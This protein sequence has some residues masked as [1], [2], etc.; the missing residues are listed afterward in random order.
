MSALLAKVN[1]ER[2]VIPYNKP[3]LT[4]RETQYLV[5]A[6]NSGKISGNGRFTGKCQ[7]FFEERYGFHKTLLTSSCTDALEMTALLANI[8]PGDEVI[9]PSFTFVSTANAFALRGAKLV[10]CD[11]E[12]A[13]PNIAANRIEELV[14]SRTKAI[15]VVHYAGLSCDMDTIVE[16]ARRRKILVI[17][18][19][20][21]AIDSFYRGRP[22][23]SI[24]DMATFS[25]HE[26]K[27]VIAGEGGMLVVNDPELVRRAEII[28]EKGTDR[29]AFARGE[30][31]KY[32]WVDVGSS[33]LP[34]EITA[35]FLFAQL[36][37]LADI[38]RRRVKLWNR[39]HALFAP[40]AAKNVLRC[41]SLPPHSTVN[42]HIYYLICSSPEERDALI[43]YLQDHGITAV[44][45]YLP[46]HM[47]PFFESKHDGRALE[48]A[49]F[50]A[51]HL[52]RLPLFYD[53]DDQSQDWI[54]SC[55]FDFY[56]ESFDSSERL[57]VF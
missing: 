15:V 45:H 47:S 10:F 43:Q 31:Q 14:T 24:G 22:L 48:M 29:A 38:Q 30:V 16:V 17:E 18:D 20:A 6:V 51:S 12:K 25:F 44:F 35:A 46:L 28:W 9:L 52:I 33:F 57:H 4:G 19:A 13:T 8:Q 21:H 54:A 55:V 32:N 53:L 23:G 37:H 41:P 26:T 56:Q 40:L 11:S 42:G 2:S 50:Y 49:E 39:Y 7:L 1:K 34:S 5:E 27:N 3:F 36:E